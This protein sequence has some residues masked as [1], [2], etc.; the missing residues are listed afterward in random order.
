MPATVLAQAAGDEPGKTEAREKVV[1]EQQA[2]TEVD[3]EDQPYV[4]EDG[5]VDFGTYNGY[6]RYHS[7]CHVCHGPD[8][9][10]SSYAPALIEFDPA[11]SATRAISRR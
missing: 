1:E 2:E 3:W 7:F 10:G 11:R 9:L 4:V 5:K 8:A 6:R